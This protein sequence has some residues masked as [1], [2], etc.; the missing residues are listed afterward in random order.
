VTTNAGGPGAADEARRVEERAAEVRLRLMQTMDALGHKRRALT[1]ASQSVSQRVTRAIE[2]GSVVLTLGGVVLVTAT[3]LGVGLA[4]YSVL[5]R[6]RRRSAVLRLWNLVPAL[7][8]RRPTPPRPQPSLL[9]RLA[10]GLVM[11]MASTGLKLV[12]RQLAAARP[13]ESETELDGTIRECRDK[14]STQPA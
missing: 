5:A 14:P 4:A 13:T 1:V 2:R 8:W 11:G 9:A 7:E 12:M 3:A 6:A 10:S